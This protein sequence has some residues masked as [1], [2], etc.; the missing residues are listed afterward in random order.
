LPQLTI[1]K[2]KITIQKYKQMIKNW[3]NNKPDPLRTTEGGLR[4]KN[5]YRS[6]RRV[7]LALREGSLEPS[8]IAGILR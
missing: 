8:V 6:I 5:W 7:S 4:K 3:S 1:S 2:G